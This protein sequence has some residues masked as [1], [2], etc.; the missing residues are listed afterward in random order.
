MGCEEDLGLGTVDRSEMQVLTGVNRLY[1]YTLGIR[2]G[3]A[4]GGRKG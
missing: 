3:S 1:S 4:D 2:E